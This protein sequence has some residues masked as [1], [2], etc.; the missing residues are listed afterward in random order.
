MKKIVLLSDGT[1]NGAA[2]RHRTNVWRLY[3]ALDTQ[4]GDQIAFYD[5]GVG[6][7]EFWLFK[8]LGGA[9][10]FGLQRN[11][12][13]LYK[14]LCRTYDS[15]DQIYLFGFSRGAF[16]V[17]MLAGMIEDCGLYKYYVDEDDL[18]KKARGNFQRYHSKYNR[19]WLTWP[20]RWLSRRSRSKFGN[21]MPDIQFI[22]V[23]DTVDAYGMPIDWLAVVW[24]WLVYPLRFVDNSLSCK[25]KRACHA[26]SIDDERQTFHPLLWKEPGQCPGRVKQ[27]WFAGVHSDVGGGYARHELALVTLDWMI[28]EVEDG[29]S[30]GRLRF[31]PEVRREYLI[32]A[33]WHGVQH[34]SRSGVAAYYRYKPREI[35]ELCKRVGIDKPRIH[36]GVFE[37][38]RRNIV[39]Y[40]PTGLPADY[41]VVNAKCKEV[42]YES[43]SEENKGKCEYES[44]CQARKR[45]KAMRSA[46]NIITKRRCLYYA[47]LVTSGALIL[48]GF[49][50]TIHLL[51]L[52][53]DAIPLVDRWMR[54]LPQKPWWFVAI[55]AAFGVLLYLKIGWFRATQTRAMK[56]WG[57]VRKSHE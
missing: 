53:M 27:V 39:P 1:G 28:S 42:V 37:R 55:L 30:Q 17:R 41:E 3:H 51:E 5:D 36:R 4:G 56:A 34:D 48:S 20:I 6:S 50:V 9:F 31:I 44:S 13:G 16:T 2:K 25:V 52:K 26:L 45:V 38:I 40:A 32:H 46:R 57:D 12:V 49:F 18:R 35:E 21:V 24:D 19:G 22:G 14:T 29:P 7:Q 54:V 10:G 33:D 11:V 43:K 8:I 15:C 23:W 47:F